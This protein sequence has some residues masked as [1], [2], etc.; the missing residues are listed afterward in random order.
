MINKFMRQLIKK[1][2]LNVANIHV[3][4]VDI[5]VYVLFF[6]DV[7][8]AIYTLKM[9]ILLKSENDSLSVNFTHFLEKTHLFTLDLI[10]IS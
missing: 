2:Y 7:N 10:F 9:N 6:S 3:T 5:L 8:H 1:I 4:N